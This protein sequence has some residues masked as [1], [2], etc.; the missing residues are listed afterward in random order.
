MRTTI[1][2]SLIFWGT[3]T[4][5][6]PNLTGILS[7]NGQKE[8]GAIFRVNTPGTTPGIIHSFDNFSSPHRPGGGV[9]AGDADWLYGML[10]YNGT[11][12]TG[13]LYKIRR[14][15]TGFQ[16]LHNI[17]NYPGSGTAPYYHT[18]GYIY[19]SNEFQVKKLDPVTTTVTNLDLNAGIYPRNL[20]IDANDWIYFPTTN[21]ALAKI[22]T[23]GTQWTQLHAFNSATEGS[24]GRAGMTEIPGDTLFGVQTYGGLFDGGT[25]YS[26]KKDGSG[27]TVH[28]QFTTATGIYPESRLE[29][30]DG[31][32]F[33]TT[34]Q[35]GS[36]GYG[37]LYTI[38]PD[39][40]GFR[41]IHHFQPGTYGTSQV[42]G[43]IKITTNGR[44]MGTFS[45]FYAPAFVFYRCFKIDTSGQNFEGFLN[46]DQRGFG[47]F[48]MDI[49]FIDDEI[50]FLTTQEMGR[51]D[52]GVLSQCDTS[53]FANSLYHFG[54]SPN[55]FRPNT[56]IKASDGKLYGTA[57]IGGTDGNGVVFSMNTNGT[58]Y[59]LLHEFNDAEGYQPSVQLLEASDGKLYGGCE[60][61]GPNGGGC[62]YRMDKTG[63]NFEL[64]FSFPVLSNGYTPV[65]SL[66]EDNNGILY[67]TAFYSS[68]GSGSVFRVNKDGS[69]FASL[70]IFNIP[71]ELVFPYG[72]MLANGYL[73]GA[74]GYGGAD[75]K[76]GIFRIKTDGTAYQ[77]LHE[78][79][80]TTDGSAPAAPPILASNGKFYGTTSSGG[81]NGHGTIYRIDSDGSNYTILKHMLESTDG[82]YLWSGVIQA[83]DGLIYG[84]SFT[85][86]TAGNGG[87]IFSLNLDGAGFSTV[88][89][90]S[91]DTEGYGSYGLLDLNGGFVLPVE[92]ISFDAEKRGQTVLLTWKT[93]SEQNTDRFDIQ[94]SSDGTAYTNIGAVVAAGNTTAISSYSFTDAYP[95]KGMN[96]YR[97]KQVDMDSRSGFSRVV[98]IN[99]ETLNRAVITPNPATNYLGIRLPPGNNYIMAA[100]VDA[101][102][103]LIMQKNITP[104]TGSLQ[105]NIGHLPV[106]W[107]LL[108][109]TGNKTQQIPFLK[110]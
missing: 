1:L 93:A 35:G 81:L 41:V 36:F 24:N 6:Q 17:D 110:Q 13:G 68:P 89:S 83:S 73:Y 66:V 62:L 88:R 18:D 77:M 101:T 57:I 12:N 55:G 61:G 25:I 79:S 56:L 7:Y 76:G 21:S 52:G 50:F 26:V 29:Y 2:F 46:T 31:K 64:I 97:L 71:G 105:L 59:T 48:N 108:R 69:N 85:G 90:F 102:G 84:I 92:W 15:G 87:T 44:I 98:T 38:N 54:Y 91:S 75:N 3:W 23:D 8:G 65:G 103:K 70:K 28:H 5:A 43:N 60:W 11:T 67:G 100:I 27:F 82:G 37:V 104:A 39:G 74:C 58:G 34:T 78:L 53:G 42:T 95:L 109:L 4:C 86:N 47:H 14:D 63:S 19:F 94:R 16:M 33:G 10:T 51:H 22:K 32:L 40:T 30:F 20:L 9:C 72:I 96:Y 80:G 49:H 107:Y 45:Q 106:G 99:I